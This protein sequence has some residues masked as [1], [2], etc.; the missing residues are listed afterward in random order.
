MEDKIM[1]EVGEII[2]IAKSGRLIV[3]INEQMRIGSKLI[4]NKGNDI[5]KVIDI[6]G[7]TYSPYASA[8]LLTDRVNKLINTKVY[9]A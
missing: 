6:I 4:N 1:K 3:K 9:I 8:I 5:A 2:H 7:P